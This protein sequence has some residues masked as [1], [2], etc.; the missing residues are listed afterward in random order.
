MLV[1]VGI[2]ADR[3]TAA[4]VDFPGRGWTAGLGFEMAFGFCKKSL[5]I[6]LYYGRT[7]VAT[8]FRWAARL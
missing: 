1:D 7:D 2:A 4:V 8:Y 5:T 3:T 6:S